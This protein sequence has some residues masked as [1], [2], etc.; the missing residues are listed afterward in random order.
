M[1]NL[2][3]IGFV[4]VAYVADYGNFHVVPATIDVKKAKP[5]R[6]IN[7]TQA[8]FL[9]A[10]WKHCVPVMQRVHAQMQFKAD[11]IK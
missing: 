4:Q 1:F 2:K 5:K 9:T 6:T 3:A 8:R 11:A 10:S 7:A